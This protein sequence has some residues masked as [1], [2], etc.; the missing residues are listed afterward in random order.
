MSYEKAWFF[1]EP[2]DFAE[3]TEKCKQGLNTGY[4]FLILHSSIVRIRTSQ[5][6][7]TVVRFSLT[8]V[9]NLDFSSKNSVEMR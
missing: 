3:T 8:A 4:A 7:R 2:D 9:Q 1:W 6:M 5:I